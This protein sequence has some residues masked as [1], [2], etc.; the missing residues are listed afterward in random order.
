MTKNVFIVDTNVVIA[1]LLSSDSTS[2]T[3]QILDAM[4]N[5][6]ILTVLSPSLLQEY[7]E[8]LLRPKIRKYHQLTEQQLE[9]LLSEIVANAIWCEP[10]E[11]L[12]APDKGDAH[13]WSLLLQSEHRVLITGDLLLLQNAPPGKSVISPARYFKLFHTV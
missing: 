1:G 5:G 8:V 12:S 11:T 4:L 3:V 6:S 10:T 9:Q 7:H 2:P 13:I